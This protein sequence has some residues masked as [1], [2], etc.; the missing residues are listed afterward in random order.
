MST[1]WKP[2]LPEQKPYCVI[3]GEKVTAPPF[4]A[5]KPKRGVAIYAHTAC[6]QREKEDGHDTQP[7]KWTVPKCMTDQNPHK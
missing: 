6:L 2:K 7:Q 5:S 4:I 3:C 1:E